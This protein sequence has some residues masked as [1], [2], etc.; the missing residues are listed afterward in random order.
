MTHRL[1]FYVLLNFRGNI[2]LKTFPL[3]I[4]KFSQSEILLSQTLGVIFILEAPITER[5][6]RIFVPGETTFCVT[7]STERSIFRGYQ[8]NFPHDLRIYQRCRGSLRL[9]RNI[10]VKEVW[11]LNVI[12]LVFRYK[13]NTYKEYYINSTYWQR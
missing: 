9:L 5:E 13:D 4:I 1:N 8:I 12:R 3:R 7:K 2:F 10:N 6:I 11:L